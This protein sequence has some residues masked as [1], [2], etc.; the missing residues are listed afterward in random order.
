ML[1]NGFATADHCVRACTLLIV[2]LV[3]LHRFEFKV[4]QNH[5][6]PGMLAGFEKENGNLNVLKKEWQWI[7][8]REL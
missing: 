4:L 5:S 3:L 8:V 7:G 1:F 6:I 2:V